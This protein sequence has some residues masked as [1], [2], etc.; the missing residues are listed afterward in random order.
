MGFTG[1]HTARQFLD[2][3]EDVVISWYQTWREPSFIKD[4]YKKRVQMERL[5][6]TAGHDVLDVT[7]RHKVTGICHLAV[8]GLAALSPAEDFRVNML[9]L[10]N[11]LEAAHLFDIKRI[12]VA[13]SQTV[14]T[15]VTQGPFREDM[16]LPVESRTGTE[17][18]K[19]AWEI[20]ALHWGERTGVEVVMLRLGGIWGPL[21]HTLASPISR[22]CHAAAKGV[23]ADLASGRGGVPFEDD[24]QDWGYVKNLALGIQ[25]LHTTEKLNHKIYNVGGGKAVPNRDLV[26]AIKHVVPGAQIELQ[27]GRSPR[28][29]PDGHMDLTRLESDTGYKPRFDL[30]TAVAEYIDWLCVNPF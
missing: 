6:V 15:G 29:R 13:S 3:G 24:T 1:L 25:L 10:I 14:Y 17:A 7:R 5:D 12:T 11:V 23:P 8:P 4:E 9:G 27:P 20:L 26:D 21:Y 19:K 30:Q 22:M 18:F 28:W 16:S 2:V